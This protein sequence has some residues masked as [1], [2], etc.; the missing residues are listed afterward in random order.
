VLLAFALLA[1]GH[2]SVAAQ[3]SLHPQL[4]GVVRNRM[5][6]VRM[7][8]GEERRYELGAYAEILA[9]FDVRPFAGADDLTKGFEVR[10]WFAHSLALDTVSGGNS[11]T[12][13]FVRFGADVGWLFPVAGGLE[14]GLA[15]GFV[16]DGYY[17][18]ARTPFPSTRYLSIR[19]ALRVRQAIR[20]EKLALDLDAAYRA[21]VFDRGLTDRFGSEAQIRAFDLTGAVTGALGG[22]T[23]ALR[24][25]WVSYLFELEGDASEARASDGSD[26]SLRMEVLVGWMIGT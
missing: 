5:G 6:E 18:G 7:E 9:R 12:S 13:R 25:S 4:G 3:P 15:T 16:F 11:S 26:H 24:L 1:W 19:P 2:G 8:S 22:F 14:L 17:L 20:G 23:W 10:S 21:V